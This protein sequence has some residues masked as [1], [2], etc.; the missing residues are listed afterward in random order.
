MLSFH[1]QHWLLRR[2][3]A[4]DPISGAGTFLFGGA[5]IM[6]PES[7]DA[8]ALRAPELGTA[9]RT[10][11]RSARRKDVSDFCKDVYEFGVF[12]FV[13]FLVLVVDFRG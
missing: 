11:A 4:R 12:M 13:E 2:T 10:P 3:I 1:G 8:G 7:L 6:T 5:G 9:S